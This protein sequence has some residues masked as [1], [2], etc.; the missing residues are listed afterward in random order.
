MPELTM[1]N[2]PPEIIVM[3]FKHLSVTDLQNCCQTCLKWEGIAVDCFFQPQLRSLA[4][5]DDFTKKSFRK[6]GWTQI[7]Q[8]IAIEGN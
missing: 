1:D 7:C 2:L 5:F 3:I 4:E 8:V 6:K